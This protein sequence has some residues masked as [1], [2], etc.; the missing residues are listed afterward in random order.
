MP[1]WVLE[2]VLAVVKHEDEHGQDQS[3]CLAVALEGVPADVVSQAAGYAQGKRR[4]VE[5]ARRGES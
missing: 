5:D 2:L 3:V 1:D 4:A